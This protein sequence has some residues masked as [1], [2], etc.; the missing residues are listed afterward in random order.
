M[1]TNAVLLKSL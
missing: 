1:Q